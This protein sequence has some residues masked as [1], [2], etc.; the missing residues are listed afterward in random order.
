MAIAIQCANCAFTYGLQDEDIHYAGA[1]CPQCHT[2]A[3]RVHVEVDL[4]EAPTRPH[5]VVIDALRQRIAGPF[6]DPMAAERWIMAHFPLGHPR[7]PLDV[8]RDTPEPP[9]TSSRRSTPVQRE[10]VPALI[11]ALDVTLA[12]WIAQAMLDSRT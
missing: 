6:T 1:L 4:P 8:V 12:L 10:P 7:G 11:D 2:M 5:W 3:P 9:R